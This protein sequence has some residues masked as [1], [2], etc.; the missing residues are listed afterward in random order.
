[1]N[2]IT[3]TLFGLLLAALVFLVAPISFFLG[4]QEKNLNLREMPTQEIA[5]IVMFVSDLK[6]DR[7]IAE[8]LAYK[9]LDQMRKS[10]KKKSVWLIHSPIS[11]KKGSSYENA[12]KLRET[13]N[14]EKFHIDTKG[15]R[16]AFDIKESFNVITDI[17]N[18]TADSRSIICDFTSGTKPMSLGMALAC[19][20][21][22][23][24]VYFPQTE[25]NDASSYL[26][27]NL[28]DDYIDSK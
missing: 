2:M 11:N 16:N 26:H 3:L 24:L 7:D 10:Q 18:S 27:F 9:I 8:L 13:F 6:D 1:M 20:G 5:S 19:R 15:V 21:E 14:D 17:L 22:V 28:G 23:R 4:R 12:Y 25:K